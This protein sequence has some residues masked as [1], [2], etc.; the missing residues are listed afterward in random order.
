MALI[1]TDNLWKT[2]TMG[3]EKV[4]ALRSVSM[5]IE[6][7]EYVAIMGPSGSG[8]SHPDEPDRLAWIRRP[9]GEYW[10]N[11]KRVRM[12]SDNELANIRNR[13]IG[14]GLPDVQPSAARYL[15]C[16]TWNCR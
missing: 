7:G 2:Y 14:F 15:P 12:M 5:K 13:E 16:T 9:R 1:E 3:S 11:E 6:K 4:H 10:L 8:K